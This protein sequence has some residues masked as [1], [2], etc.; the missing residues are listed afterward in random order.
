MTPAARQPGHPLHRAFLFPSSAFVW[1]MKLSDTAPARA[2]QSASAYLIPHLICLYHSAHLSRP[3]HLYRSRIP[4]AA[5]RAR[6]QRMIDH[7]WARI[8]GEGSSGMVRTSVVVWGEMSLEWRRP[9]KRKSRGRPTRRF[10]QAVRH[11][12]SNVALT[13]FPQRRLRLIPLPVQPSL[14]LV[15]VAGVPS[16]TSVAPDPDPGQSSALRCRYRIR[17]PTRVGKE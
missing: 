2:S 4:P 15:S 5:L 12:G 10:S 7:G 9:W 11:C 13:R 8:K 3:H 1:S 17:M 6:A 16:C 14:I